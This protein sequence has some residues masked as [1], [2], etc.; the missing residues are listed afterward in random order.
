MKNQFDVLVIDDQLNIKDLIQPLV[1][2]L[3]YKKI[4]LTVTYVH[5]IKD[6]TEQINKP[7]DIILFDS[8]LGS[9]DFAKIEGV[10]QGFNLIKN[11]RK[12]NKRTKIIFYSSSFNLNHGDQIPLSH[13]DYFTMIN[14][15][16]IYKIVYKNNVEE[17]LTAIEDAINSLDIVMTTLDKM[18]EEYSELGLSYKIDNTSIPLEDLIKDF[19]MDGEMSK[20]FR[21]NLNEMVATYFLNASI[22]D[23]K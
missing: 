19:K 4:F 8:Q 3:S 18:V 22:D 12:T 17:L 15:L 14:E 10:S 6:L 13:R 1:E 21:K 9:T 23:R 16:N 5:E 7:F 20:K 11:F 2:I